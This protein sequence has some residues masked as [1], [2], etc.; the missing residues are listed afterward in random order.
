MKFLIVRHLN[1]GYSCSCC[2][3]EWTETEEIDITGDDFSP[4]E[5]EEIKQKILKE[6]PTG[7]VYLVSEK[8][9]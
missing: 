9:R 5:I 6:N 3:Q 2:K 4:T 7:D 8:I 1:N